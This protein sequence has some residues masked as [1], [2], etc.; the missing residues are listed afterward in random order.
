[1]GLRSGDWKYIDPAKGKTPDWLKNKDVPTGLQ[2]T[3]QL[4]NLEDDPKENHNLSG[5]YPDIVKKLAQELK[6]IVK[7]N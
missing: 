4:Y 2:A 3:P 1:M 7:G 6:Q 5:E